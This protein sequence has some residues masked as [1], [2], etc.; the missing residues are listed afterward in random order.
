M[1]DWRILDGHLRSD[2]TMGGRADPGSPRVPEKSRRRA[3]L[4]TLTIAAAL[5]ILPGRLW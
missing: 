1:I 4:A 2:A 5:L 3:T